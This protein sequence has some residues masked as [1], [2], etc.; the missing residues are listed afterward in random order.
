MIRHLRG[1]SQITVEKR[2]RLA[3]NQLSVSRVGPL[4]LVQLKR[5]I[6]E[7][8][9][10]TFNHVPDSRHAAFSLDNPE[11]YDVGRVAPGKTGTRASRVA[12][13]ATRAQTFIGH[14]RLACRANARVRISQRHPGGIGPGLPGKRFFRIEKGARHPAGI[15]AQA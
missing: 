2:P 1:A 3:V 7:R 6:V 11:A 13:I 12:G 14:L 5:A 15:V 10:I 4:A 8:M 9:M